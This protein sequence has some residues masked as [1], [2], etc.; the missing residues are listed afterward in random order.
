MT[1]YWCKY[2]SFRC[3]CRKYTKGETCPY[4]IGV[5]R[6]GRTWK[7][8]FS[9]QILVFHFC[10]RSERQHSAMKFTIR[11]RTNATSECCHAVLTEYFPIVS[12]TLPIPWI[13][14]RQKNSKRFYLLS[15]ADRQFIPYEVHVA[16]L[17]LISHL[18]L[19]IR[20]IFLLCLSESIIWVSTNSGFVFFA[21]R[22]FCR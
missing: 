11:R 14:F 20:S 22:Y 12:I 2:H 8:R 9:N 1:P 18:Y 17:G 19:I 15:I 7:K 4:N 16:L 3:N 21:A 10:E 13:Y 6:K 5:K